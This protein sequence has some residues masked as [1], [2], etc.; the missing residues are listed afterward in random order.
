MS[1]QSRGVEEVAKVDPDPF[2]QQLLQ[3]LFPLF[4]VGSISWKL[5]QRKVL[6]RHCTLKQ[7]VPGTDFKVGRPLLRRETDPTPPSKQHSPLAPSARDRLETFSTASPS[8][9]S[10]TCGT[11]ACIE[12]A[13][14]TTTPS[15]CC[16]APAGSR[17]YR[18]RRLFSGPVKRMAPSRFA[19]GAVLCPKCEDYVIEIVG[20]L[21][22][23][24]EACNQVTILTLDEYSDLHTSNQALREMAEHDRVRRAR[25][26]WK[27]HHGIDMDRILAA[28]LHH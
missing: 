26:Y 15:R 9:S 7:D 20:T 22:G 14:T 10:R 3:V 4:E 21:R 24:C 18:D 1:E 28:T 2:N 5:L 27:L 8:S 16:S 23:R 11:R 12:R 17:R 25:L 19:K 6:L 13:P